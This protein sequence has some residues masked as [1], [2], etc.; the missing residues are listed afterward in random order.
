VNE[1]VPRRLPGLLLAGVCAVAAAVDALY[2]LSGA[3]PAAVAIAAGPLPGGAVLALDGLSA[4]FLLIVL[5]AATAAAA[6]SSTARPAGV[7]LLAAFVAGMALCLAAGDGLV[8]L[9]G[10]ELMSA[11]SFVLL[12]SAGATGDAAHAGRRATILYGGMAMFSAL[13]LI[14]GIGL[15]GGGGGL[16]FAAMRAHPPQGV[17]AAGAFAL[18]LLGAGAKAGLVPLHVWLPPAHAAAPAPVSALMSGAMTKV[19][20]Y[21]LARV[22]FDLIGPVQPAAWG[23]VL[24]LLGTGGAVLG[25]ARANVET[26]LKLILGCST[27]ENIGLITTGLGVALVARSADLP[28]LASLAL[29][30]ALLQALAHGLFKPLLFLAAGAVQH[31]AGS[32]ELD[33]LGGLIQRMPVTTGC[34]LVGAASL[35]ALPPSAGFA[36]EWL[37]LQ[38][39]FAAPRAGGLAFQVVTCVV[40]AA[41]AFAMALAAAAAVRLVGVG[42]LGR[43]RTPRGASAEEVGATPRAVLMALAGLLAALGLVPAAALILA[44][45]ASRQ[46]LAG[47]LIGRAGLVAVR[48]QPD[49]ALYAP[50]G[51][52][53]LLGLAAATILTIARRHGRAGAVRGPAWD[54]GFGPPAPWFPLGDPAAQASA[55]GQSQILR[56]TVGALLLRARERATP[57]ELTWSAE[58]PF[59]VSLFQRLARVRDVLSG[60]AERLQVLT[61]RQALLVLFSVLVAVLAVVAVAEQP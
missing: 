25:A 27:I 21:V 42:F 15:L 50:L 33:R 13:C 24:M 5:I 7:A 22:L 17:A 29:G 43:P 48:T 44:G 2:L 4:F 57:A 39:V 34:V 58:D 56:R 54:G 10:F 18:V 37:L 28:A 3:A 52:L 53:L 19:A 14:G 60:W 47:D 49:G 41:L 20:L 1:R 6:A 31:Q 61:A 32:R 9:A 59:E 36:G 8:L 35:A 45:P 51:V 46:L 26:D 30:A 23:A 12:L 40:A 16:G 55:A 11:A 38:S